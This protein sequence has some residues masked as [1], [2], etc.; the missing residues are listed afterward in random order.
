MIP[1]VVLPEFSWTAAT[2]VDSP[3]WDSLANLP[4]EIDQKSFHQKIRNAAIHF[5]A[6][7]MFSNIQK[8]FESKDLTPTQFRE[9]LKLNFQIHL[10]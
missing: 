4:T 7:S 10:N 1:Y 9:L 2:Y 3:G 5:R 8:C 6:D